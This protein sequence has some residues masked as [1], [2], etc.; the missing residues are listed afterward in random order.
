MPK[1]N[2]VKIAVLRMKKLIIKKVREGGRQES[3]E[4][5]LDK[6]VDSVMITTTPP[7]KGVRSRRGKREVEEASP[8]VEVVSGKNLKEMA[9]MALARWKIA[10]YK[11]NSVIRKL[12]EVLIEMENATSPGWRKISNP[13]NRMRRKALSLD[14]CGK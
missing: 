13:R 7:S 6:E 1:L 9:P 10:A 3:D 14:E 5:E 12:A 11:S 8:L 2:H 4:G